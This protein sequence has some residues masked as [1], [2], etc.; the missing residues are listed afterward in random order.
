MRM[1]IDLGGTKTE[2]IALSEDGTVLARH[3]APTPAGDYPA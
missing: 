2:A 3:R 1:G